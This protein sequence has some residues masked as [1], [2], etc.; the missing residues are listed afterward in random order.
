MSLCLLRCM[1]SECNI[2]IGVKPSQIEQGRKRA[3]SG[4]GRYSHVSSLSLVKERRRLFMY[5]YQTLTSQSGKFQPNIGLLM[6]TTETGRAPFSFLRARWCC[7]LGQ[8]DPA[9]PRLPWDK[10]PTCLP[11]LYLSVLVY[12]MLSI[13]INS[14]VLGIWKTISSF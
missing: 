11:I 1:W 3:W 9:G 8:T 5:S 4:H 10:L 2:N 7:A 6:Q 12:K 13:E 14:I